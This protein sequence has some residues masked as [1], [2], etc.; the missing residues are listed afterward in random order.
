[1]VQGNKRR[2]ERKTVQKQVEFFVDADIIQA[3]SIDLSSSGIRMLTERPICIRMRVYHEGGGFDEQVAQ[4]V[5]A[6]KDKNK[7][8]YGFEFQPDPERSNQD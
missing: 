4:L 8:S 7:T 5:W 3:E 6:A 2:A 1:M